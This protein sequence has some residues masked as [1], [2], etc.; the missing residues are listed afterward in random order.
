M[1]ISNIYWNNYSI[2]VTVLDTFW[3]YS[4][5]QDKKLPFCSG[6]AKKKREFHRVISAMKETTED[7]VI[8]I[9]GVF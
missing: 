6:V 3:R 2:S 1:N 7:G 8:R 9:R 4:T 5:K